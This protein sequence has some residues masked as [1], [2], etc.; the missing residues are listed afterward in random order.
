MEGGTSPDLITTAVIVGAFVAAFLLLIYAIRRARKSRQR[1]IEE[2]GED[3]P[4]PSAKRK[5]PSLRAEDVVPEPAAP[6]PHEVRDEG[7][8][9]PTAQKV[10]L[11]P[12]QVKP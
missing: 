8:T 5:K 3:R 4:A 7:S 2:A 12:Q 10:A 1:Q 9:E 6:S 11:E